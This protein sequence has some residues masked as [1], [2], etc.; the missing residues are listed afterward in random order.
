MVAIFD[1]NI[2]TS[3]EE[4]ESFLGIE[5]P[6]KD[7]SGQTAFISDVSKFAEENPND[8]AAWDQFA[9]WED[10][11]VDTSVFRINSP[12]ELPAKYPALVLAWIDDDYDR[13]GAV[14]ARIVE[15]VYESEFNP[16]E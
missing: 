6:M 3:P 1:A 9:Y 2:N 12:E 5:F 13:T 11:G 4:I 15:F 16:K 8:S 14:I 10:Q 7:E